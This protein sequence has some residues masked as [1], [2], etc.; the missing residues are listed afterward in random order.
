MIAGPEPRLK[1]WWNSDQGLLYRKHLEK[2]LED[3][4]KLGDSYD[5]GNESQRH[6]ASKI[7]ERVKIYQELLDENKLMDAL[8]KLAQEKK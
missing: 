7:Q 4:R 8:I 1:A 5:L 3:A 2:K 6:L